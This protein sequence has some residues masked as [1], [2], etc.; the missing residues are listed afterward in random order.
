MSAILNNRDIIQD[1][2]KLSSQDGSTNAKEVIVTKNPLYQQTPG[3]RLALSFSD[4][5]LVNIAYCSGNKT[6]FVLKRTILFLNNRI[7]PHFTNNRKLF[8]RSGTVGSNLSLA[9]FYIELSG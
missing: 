9:R 7:L 8:Y 4:K 1:G 6:F 3:Q 5:K 2:F